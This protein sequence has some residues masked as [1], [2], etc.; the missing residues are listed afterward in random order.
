MALSQF[1]VINYYVLPFRISSECRPILMNGPPSWR[2]FSVR[3]P[4]DN[5]SLIRK[6]DMSICMNACYTWTWMVAIIFYFR[7][8]TE[9]DFCCV[10]IIDPMSMSNTIPHYLLFTS[11][12]YCIQTTVRANQESVK[13]PYIGTNVTVGCRDFFL[14]R[15]IIWVQLSKSNLKCRVNFCGE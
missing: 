10:R 6:V 4:V 14:K 9:N 11:C 13:L 5:V 1:V 15:E 3:L 7:F 8:L 12:C 2:I